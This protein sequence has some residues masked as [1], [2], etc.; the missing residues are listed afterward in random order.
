MAWIGCKQGPRYGKFVTWP[1]T[2]FVVDECLIS[3]GVRGRGT[4]NIY[5]Y[6]ERDLDIV[7]A[8]T[9]KNRG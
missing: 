3:R 7:S 9:V 6:R 1:W 4:Q 5:I 8:P 2:L